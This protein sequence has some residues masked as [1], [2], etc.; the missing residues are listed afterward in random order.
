MEVEARFSP[1]GHLTQLQYQ[2]MDVIQL[3]LTWV[4]WP[5]GEKRASTSVQIYL[6][7]SER[8]SSQVNVSARSPDPS[9]SL[10]R[11]D[12]GLARFRGFY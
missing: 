5:N 9:F 11:F 7:Q 6:D 8:K 3:A 4:K 12:Q 2:R 10:C 1:F